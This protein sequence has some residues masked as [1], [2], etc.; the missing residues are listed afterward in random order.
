PLT[1]HA[2][3]Y[4][5]GVFEGIRS[6]ATRDGA[7]VF[8]LPEHLERMRQGAQALGI[9]LDV[10]QASAATLQVLRANQHRDAYIRPLAW[11]GTGS[12]GLDI[13]PQSQHLMVASVASN[14]H[15]GGDRTRLTVTSWRRNPATSLPPL[16]LSGG[17]VNS[18]LA[19]RDAK[20]RGFDEALFVDEQ[21]QVVECTGANVFFVKDGRLTAVEHRDALPGI[22]RATLIELS[23]AQSRPATLDELR[24]ADEVFVCGTAA[25]V[26]SIAELDGREY[27]EHP[28]T[29]EL[30]A[31]YARAVRGESAAHAHWLTA[32]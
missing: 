31:L 13:A 14:V 18:I 1:T 12:L 24:D 16:K 4:G 28:V 11:A 19:K 20:G 9:Q 32:V 7:A 26:C 2:M 25:E 8:R 6:Y 21:G 17:Y 22:T 10:A 23:G 5:T 29:R 3:H 15:L 27:G 30:A